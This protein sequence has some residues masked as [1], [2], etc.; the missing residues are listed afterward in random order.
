MS[1]EQPLLKIPSSPSSSAPFS[2]DDLQKGTNVGA[3]SAI[4]AGVVEATS[5]VEMRA[6]QKD[7]SA[8]DSQECENDAD[9]SRLLG[10]IENIQVLKAFFPLLP[11]QARIAI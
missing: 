2:E 3:C 9:I 4:A 10:D 11:T 6:D 1:Q 8:S 5:T 7:E